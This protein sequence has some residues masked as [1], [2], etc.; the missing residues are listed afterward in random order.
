MSSWHWLS[1]MMSER[2]SLG[3]VYRR[4]YFPSSYVD[5]DI[6]NCMHW[7]DNNHQCLL[8]FV[9]PSN[10]KDIFVF[11]N[12]YALKR[13]LE[14]KGLLTTM[15]GARGGG[16]GVAGEMGKVEENA[17]TSRM[18]GSLTT[19]TWLTVA[20]WL[21]CG[22]HKATSDG[23]GTRDWG[24]SHKERRMVREKGEWTQLT[25]DLSGIRVCRI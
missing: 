22:C 19:I 11:H 10:Q 25:Y 14:W 23:R 1:N 15:V 6:S 4:E 16:G 18:V 17:K 13:V 24:Q 5:K 3:H 20:C 7:W 9:L 12:S 21:H 8:N 2:N